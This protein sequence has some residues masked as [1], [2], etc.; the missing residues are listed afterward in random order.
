MLT[1]TAV[2]L[3]LSIWI[4]T[5]PYRAA[6]R[7]L[8]STASIEYFENLKRDVE[9][10]L[11]RSDECKNPELYIAEEADK[12]R[13]CLIE[14][15]SH[16]KTV[17]GTYIT[18]MKASM[19]LG[20]N[21]EDEQVRSAALASIANARS[22]MVQSM[23]QYERLWNLTEAHDSSIFLSLIDGRHSTIDRFSKE[24]DFMDEAEN[25]V[26]Q[27]EMSSKQRLWRRDAIASTVK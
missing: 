11:Q 2:A 20:K 15:L 23:K 7:E 3:S 14:A 19:W 13:P 24:A 16:T 4:D 10:E 17:A 18:A 27:P 5:G 12:R 25:A 1:V 6:Q 9:L 22:R 21:P 26:M 8:A